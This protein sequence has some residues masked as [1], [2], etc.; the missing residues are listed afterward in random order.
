M[1]CLVPGLWSGREGHEDRSSQGEF[2]TVKSLHAAT[3]ESRAI[4]SSVSCG[5]SEEE[6]NNSYLTTKNAGM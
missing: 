4:F 2:I 6:N 3:P 5:V 1:R